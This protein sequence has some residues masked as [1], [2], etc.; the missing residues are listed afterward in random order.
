MRWQ[1]SR[2]GG[3]G[4]DGALRE[5]VLLYHNKYQVLKKCRVVGEGLDGVV[6]LRVISTMKF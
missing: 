4:E 2:W 6:K 1:G 5:S 3:E